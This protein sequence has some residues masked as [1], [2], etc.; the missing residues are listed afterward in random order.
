MLASVSANPSFEAA[1]WQIARP[2]I[3]TMPASIHAPFS[4][5]A[6]PAAPI[7]GVD[8]AVFALD[9]VGVD[10]VVPPSVLLPRMPMNHM[11]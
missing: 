10:V 11:T 8:T 3:A 7:F 5:F 4:T 6:N 2:D 9:V 1:T